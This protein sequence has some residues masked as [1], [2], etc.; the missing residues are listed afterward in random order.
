MASLLSLTSDTARKEPINRYSCRARQ[1]AP[2]SFLAGCWLLA[3]LQSSF[4]RS[5][6]LPPRFTGF[7]SL[8][9]TRTGPIAGSEMPRSLYSHNIA[10]NSSLKDD[11]VHG[12]GLTRA[13]EQFRE[14]DS[15]LSDASTRVL[16]TPVRD[17]DYFYGERN[18]YCQLQPHESFSAKYPINCAIKSRYSV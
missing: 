9:R 14:W 18:A 5:S 7:S 6:R 10:G 17:D 1:N 13:A 11:A 12:I 3:S 15:S 4:L 2:M 8:F 16:F